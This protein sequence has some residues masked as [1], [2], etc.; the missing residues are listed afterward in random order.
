[1]KGSTRLL[2][3]VGE[4]KALG[5][6]EEKGYQFLGSNFHTRWGELDLIMETQ[7]HIVF[8]EVKQRLGT[9]HGEPEEAVTAYKQKHLTRAA[10]IYLKGRPLTKGIRFDVISLSPSGIRHIENAFMVEGPYYY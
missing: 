1:M 4:K 6:L 7:S 3:E 10:L 5:Y 8:V 9:S 2:G